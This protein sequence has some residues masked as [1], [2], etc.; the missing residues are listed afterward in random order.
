MVDNKMEMNALTEE[1]FDQL[2]FRNDENYKRLL[3]H[4]EV[5]WLQECLDRLYALLVMLRQ[6]FAA[7]F[8]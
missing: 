7:R 3:L 8:N 4:T 2:C 5:S 6:R 1:L